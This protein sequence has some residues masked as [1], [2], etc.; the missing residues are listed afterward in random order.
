M[1][2]LQGQIE[3]DGGKSLDFSNYP[4]IFMVWD[5]LTTCSFVYI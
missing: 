4:Y 2:F 1:P 3:T 5:Y